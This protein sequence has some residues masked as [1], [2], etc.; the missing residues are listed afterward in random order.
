[1][2]KVNYTQSGTTRS[3]ILI[4]TIMPDCALALAELARH[5]RE[6]ALGLLN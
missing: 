2:L 6:T 3:N 4:I 5:W 1:M